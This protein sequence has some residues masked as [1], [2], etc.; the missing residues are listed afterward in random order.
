[1]K[2][3][4]GEIARTVHCLRPVNCVSQLHACEDKTRVSCLNVAHKHCKMA[5]PALVGE[6][7]YNQAF[8]SDD[9]RQ[10]LFSSV[11]IDKNGS[12]G[13][14]RLADEGLWEYLLC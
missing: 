13:L 2:V 6:V 11:P 10:G 5:T 12:L 9:I 3:W 7:L 8:S 14:K 1:M 4:Y